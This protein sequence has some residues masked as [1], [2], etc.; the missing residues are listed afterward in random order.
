MD[1]TGVKIKP[2]EGMV[3]LAFVDSDEEV[4]EEIKKSVSYNSTPYEPKPYCGL[5][6]IVLGIGPNVTTCKVGDT[7]VVGPYARDGLKI[8]ENSVLT[9]AYHIK[10]TIKT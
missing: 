6:A 2:A 8:G 5:L 4:D 7:V 1:L 3:A 10:A 9:D